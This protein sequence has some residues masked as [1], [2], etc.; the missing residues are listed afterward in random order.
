MDFYSYFKERFSWGSNPYSAVEKCR[1]IVDELMMNPIIPSRIS[2]E[3]A[4]DFLAAVRDFAGDGCF[5]SDEFATI[6]GSLTGGLRTM[7]EEV[8]A[9]DEAFGQEMADAGQGEGGGPLYTPGDYEVRQVDLDG[10]ELEDDANV[11]EQ[12]QLMLQT[13]QPG[14]TIVA[15]EVSR[16]AR[17]TRQLC[18]IMETIRDRHLCL[19][20]VGSITLDCRTGQPDPMSEAFLQIAGVFSQLE[21]SMIRAR[22]RSG[23]ENARAKGVRLGRPP[24]CAEGVPDRFVR[25][26]AGYLQG[27]Y[28]VSELSRLTGVSRPTVYRYIKAMEAG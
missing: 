15:L 12:Q 7:M 3:A 19:Q 26:Y 24:I 6:L 4:V 28:N 11:K 20:I 27:R 2:N 22:V 1:Q 9:A 18:E 14:D 5:V 23:M 17:S 10:N 16:L 8:E 21:L 13:A 25:Y